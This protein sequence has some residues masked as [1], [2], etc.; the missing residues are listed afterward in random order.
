MSLTDGG[1]FN[2]LFA[3]ERY[4][5]ENI[6]L[7]L[8]VTVTAAD[9]A[10][11]TLALSNGTSLKYDALVLATGASAFVP[12][13]PGIDSCSNVQVL[14]SAKD[15]LAIQAGFKN[16]KDKNIVVIGGGGYIGLETAAS[17]KK[18]GGNVTV[19]EREERLLARVAPPEALAHFFQELHTAKGVTIKTGGVSAQAILQ[20]K[21]GT[22]VTGTDGVAYP[23]DLVLVGVGVR[24]N[25][26]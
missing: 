19:L 2:P 26:A 6:T 22:T 12:P 14:R 18:I 16:A 20:T 1:D 21:D 24:P 9:A 7:A 23:A 13:I 10:S 11:K 15:A 3:A 17:L 4:E 5:E 25:S 8:G